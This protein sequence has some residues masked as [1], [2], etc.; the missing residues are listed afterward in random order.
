MRYPAEEKA[1]THEKILA[2]A[3]RSFREHG[4]EGNGIGQVMKELGLT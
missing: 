1:E 3:A 2:T 4:C